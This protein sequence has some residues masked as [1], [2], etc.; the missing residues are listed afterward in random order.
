[1]TTIY[2]QHSI[3][4]EYYDS[5]IWDKVG[6]YL[7]QELKLYP[8]NWDRFDGNLFKVLNIMKKINKHIIAKY[9]E[10]NSDL[11]NGIMRRKVID[12]WDSQCKPEG[13]QYH[14]HVLVSDDVITP[15]HVEHIQII[16]YC[17]YCSLYELID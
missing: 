9:S 17:L 8:I 5:N 3:I 16:E 6:Q 2:K 15:L 10:D 4:N 1:M 14:S 7:E 11:F 12:A 13:I